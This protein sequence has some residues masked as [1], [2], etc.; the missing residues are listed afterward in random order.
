MSLVAAHTHTH[1]H[2]SRGIE[3]KEAK[4]RMINSALQFITFVRVRAM[5]NYSIDIQ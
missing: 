1:T 5:C 3:L 2:K 4:W